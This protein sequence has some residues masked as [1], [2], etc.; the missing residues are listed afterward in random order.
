MTRTD[1]IPIRRATSRDSAIIADFNARMAEETERKT[2]DPATLDRGVAAALADGGPATYFVAEA[3]GRIVGQL[4]LTTEWSDWRNG[5]FWWIQSVYVPPEARGRGVFRAL[6]QHVDRLARKTAGVCGLRLYV[7]QH[8]A[9]AKATYERLGMT[10]S[11]HVLYE[12][13]WSA[14]RPADA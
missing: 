14:D 11:G 13:D 3:D 12:V 4:M 8:N 9:D 7:E 1:A 2:L 6:Y 5:T 10:P